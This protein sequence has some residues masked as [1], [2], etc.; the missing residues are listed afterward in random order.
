MEGRLLIQAI[1]GLQGYA[2]PVGVQFSYPA[3]LCE[4]KK[5][6]FFFGVKAR[7]QEA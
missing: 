2:P 5:T 7:R 1:Y 6:T 3:E 4:P